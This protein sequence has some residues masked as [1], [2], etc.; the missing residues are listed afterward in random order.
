MKT[1]TD[2]IKNTQNGIAPRFLIMD[3]DSIVTTLFK[4]HFE[5][6]FPDA[7]IDCVN[8]PEAE[9]GY[10]VYFIDNDFGGRRLARQIADEIRRFQPNAFIVTLSLTI[11]FHQLRELV[12]SGC[13][14]VYSKN[15]P[16]SSVDVR[17]AI[18]EYLIAKEEAATLEKSG[19]TI[20]FTLQSITSLIRQW[21]RRLQTNLDA[22][23]YDASRDSQ[24]KL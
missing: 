24:P 4:R 19:K 21:N 8:K 22:K 6:H 10:D 3:D 2:I 15:T 20:N 5:T 1:N 9:P 14:A 11:D 12:N 23:A 13:N 18:R 17:K 7:E 16:D